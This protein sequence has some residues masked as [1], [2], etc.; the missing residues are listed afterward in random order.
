VNWN[1]L[2][3]SGKEI[4]RDSMNNVNENRVVYKVLDIEDYKEIKLFIVLWI[5]SIRYLILSISKTVYK[6]VW[7]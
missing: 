1:I 2:I 3:T 7:I 5:Y 6:P 4:K